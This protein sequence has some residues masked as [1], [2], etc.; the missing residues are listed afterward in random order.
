M[1]GEI[2]LTVELNELV[3]D[4]SMGALAEV[5]GR[6]RQLD[7][8]ASMGAEIDFRDLE[9]E[10]ARAK[11]SMGSEIRVHIL[12]E[13]DGR[14]NMGGTIRVSGNPDKFFKSTSM[15]GEIYATDILN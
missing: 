10:K 8:S 11:S 15:G 2:E 3:I 14:A 6:A 9:A 5:A 4:A 13:F 7:L 12:Q 1:G